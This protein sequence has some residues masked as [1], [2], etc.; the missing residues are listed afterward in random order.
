M[1]V[2]AILRAFKQAIW[3][4]W[5]EE[6]IGDP[7][8]FAVYQLLKPVG[9]LLTIGFVYIVG[10]TSA[11]G[12]DPVGFTRLFLGGVFFIYV[13][14]VSMTMGWLIHVDR[15][16]YEVLKLIYIAAPTIH[17]YILGR[18]AAT[19]LVGTLSVVLTLLLGYG[20]FTLLGYPLQLDLMA[21]N[22]PALGVALLF[23]LVFLLSL[24]YLLCGITLVSAKLQFTLSEYVASG[25]FLL[26]GVILPIDIL[27]A[28]LQ[29]V[30]QA[31]PLTHFLESVRAAFIPSLATRL[32]DSLILLAV[33]T[34]AWATVSIAI[35]MV[36]ERRCLKIGAI[37]RK[38]EY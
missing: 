30:S 22:Y 18:G 13:E 19:I 1:A 31:L 32:A 37:D 38:A 6:R 2:G 9:I 20:I 16:R 35:F 15:A 17:P 29:A 28:P 36:S 14:R 21:I 33:T 26:G 23:G 34:L 3:L 8:M 5:R 12:F 7:F 4:G 27:P 24:G 11:G 10:S 25:F